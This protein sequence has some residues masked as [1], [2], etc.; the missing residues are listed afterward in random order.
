M[1]NLLLL[2]LTE[3]C[4]LDYENGKHFLVECKKRKYFRSNTFEKVFTQFR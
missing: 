1:T 2:S 3:P 4:I